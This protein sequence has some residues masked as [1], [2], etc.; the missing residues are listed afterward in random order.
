[1]RKRR[2]LGKRRPLRRSGPRRMPP[3]LKHA[4]ALMEAGN[5]AEAGPAFEKIAQR[6]EARGGARAVHFHLRAGRAY[7]LS[8]NI[9]KGMSHLKHAL[10]VMSAKKHWEPFQRFGQRAIDELKELGLEKEAQEITV[11]LNERLPEKTV[12]SKTKSR[13]VLPTQCP[14]C[15]A[16]L[17][18]DEVTWIDQHT[19]ECAFCDNPL[20]GEG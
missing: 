12:F 20:R 18:S 8:E 6:T 14:N 3:A 17:R 4:N 7:I 16:P 13:P 5:Y 15:G 19:A 2:P 1:M 11:L 10:M 9:Q